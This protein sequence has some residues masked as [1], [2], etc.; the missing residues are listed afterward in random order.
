MKPSFLFDIKE[1]LVYLAIA[2]ENAEALLPEEIKQE[3]FALENSRQ[4]VAPWHALSE[5]Y[6]D[7]I[8]LDALSVLE[9][10]RAQVRGLQDRIGAAGREPDLRLGK[11]AKGD[12]A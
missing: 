1:G 2:A 9:A 4:N 11:W 6:P 5:K 7:N 12:Q 10:F 8:A 3:H